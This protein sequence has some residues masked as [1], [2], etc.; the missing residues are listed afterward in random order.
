MIKLNTTQLMNTEMD[1]KDFLKYSGMAVLVMTGVGAVAKN[2]NQ[3]ANTVATGSKN[4][5]TSTTARTA[6]DYSYGAAPYG[7]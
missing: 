1:R 3:V 4:G 6:A 5:G 7:V 2:F